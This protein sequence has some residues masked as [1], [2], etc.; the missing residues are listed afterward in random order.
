M[1]QKIG[2]A[3]GSALTGW[4]LTYFGFQANKVQ[5]AET[6]DGIKMFLSFLPAAGAFL[7]IFFVYRYPL[8]KDKLLQITAE[9]EVKRNQ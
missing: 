1:S 3:I 6:I 7:S 8:T 4:L 2:W 5:N 9:L